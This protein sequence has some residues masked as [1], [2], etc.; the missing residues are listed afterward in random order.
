MKEEDDRKKEAELQRRL[1]E[2]AEADE[3]NEQGELL[4]RSEALETR[5]LA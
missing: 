4:F 1:N 5:E 3:E 2:K